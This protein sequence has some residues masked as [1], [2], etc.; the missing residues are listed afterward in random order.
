MLCFM[1]FL[2]QSVKPDGPFPLQGSELA[3]LLA[4]ASIL[5]TLQLEPLVLNSV[6]H[7]QPILPCAHFEPCSVLLS[8]TEALI[9]ILQDSQLADIGATTTT[10][11]ALAAA[12]VCLSL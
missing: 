10:S 11:P 7:L 3:Q 2:K 5:R 9:R 4:K 12:A 6:L 1:N 8:F